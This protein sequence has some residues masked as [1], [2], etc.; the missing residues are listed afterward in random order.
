MLVNDNKSARQNKY[1][2]HIVCLILMGKCVKKVFFL[3]FLH[4]NV[5]ELLLE[6]SVQKFFPK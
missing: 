5:T 3:K 6:Y 4:G 1:H 2:V